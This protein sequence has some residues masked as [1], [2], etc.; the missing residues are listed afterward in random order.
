MDGSRLEG[1][2]IKGDCHYELH[3]KMTYYAGLSP[4]FTLR[5]K[6][7]THPALPPFT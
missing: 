2:G 5:M 4:V 7:G 3:L 1:A 6:R